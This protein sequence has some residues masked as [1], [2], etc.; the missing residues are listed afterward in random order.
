MLAA[1]F[2][3]PLLGDWSNRLDEEGDEVLVFSPQDPGVAPSVPGRED[4]EA[5]TLVVWMRRNVVASLSLPRRLPT[6]LRS[7]R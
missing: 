3:Y 4:L 2:G 1:S 5:E 7:C 6:S